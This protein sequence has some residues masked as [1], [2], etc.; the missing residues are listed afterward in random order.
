MTGY[1]GSGKSL[2]I[3]HLAN[4]FLE[5]QNLP[6]IMIQDKFY[7]P[8]FMSFMADIGECTVIIDE[9]GKTYPK[10][11]SNDELEGSPQQQLLSF[12]SGT[13]D[14]KRLILLAENDSWNIDKHFFDHPSRI[15]YHW[16]Y[17][18]LE[19]AAVLGYCNDN[20]TNTELRNDIIKTYQ[21]SSE[22]SFDILQSLVAQCNLFSDQAYEYIID[23]LNI[24]KKKTSTTELL[25]VTYNE[26]DVSKNVMKSDEYDD[27]Y[28]ITL[29]LTNSD[30]K[31]FQ[32]LYS[33]EFEKQED[34]LIYYEDSD[35]NLKATVLV[36]PKLYDVNAL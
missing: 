30:G 11:G 1:K 22:F 15:L 32:R 5:E 10:F 17:N 12:F 24:P 2:Q 3:K 4:T 36:K 33:L 23:G 13:N 14:M 16:E 20:L 29:K 28:R 19:E 21:E 8:D 34:N 6:V 26:N 9:F 25:K 27:E 7:G 18:R 31:E 35:N